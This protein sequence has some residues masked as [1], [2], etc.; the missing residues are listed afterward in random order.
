MDILKKDGCSF[1]DEQRQ[2][3]LWGKGAAELVAGPGSGKTFVITN[4]IKTLIEKYGVNPDSIIVIT[5]TRAA[6][7]EMRDRFYRLM[8]NEQPSVTF[9]TFH[10]LF[11]QMLKTCPDMK[12][13]T[14][15]SESGKIRILTEMLKQNG[16]YRILD[17]MDQIIGISEMFGRIKNEGNDDD[18]AIFAS[19]VSDAGIMT[20]AEK[21]RKV[22]GSYNAYM[23][24][25]NRLDFDDMI[26]RC[27]NR[28]MTDSSFCKRWQERFKYILIDEFQDIC[29]L[30][31]QVIKIIASPQ[32]NVFVVGDDDQ[33]IYG[34]RGSKPGIMREFT[35]DYPEASRMSLSTNYR[36]SETIVDIADRIISSNE[37]RI[38]KSITAY[39]KGGAQVMFICVRNRDEEQKRLTELIGKYE[40]DRSAILCRK[41]RECR[42]IAKTLLNAHVSFRIKE[43][44]KDPMKEEAIRD[45][46]GYMSFI[47]GKRDRKTFLMIMNRPVRYIR[48]EAVRTDIVDSKDIA[49]YYADNQEMK[50]RIRHLFADIDRMSE[51]RPFLAVNFIRKVEGYD[52][53]F[54]GS[55]TSEQNTDY[56]SKA[57]EFQKAAKEAGS[58]E[59]LR[60]HYK[61]IKEDFETK[62]RENTESESHGVNI[63]TY[64]GSKGLEFDTVFL[65]FANEGEVPPKQC[66]TTE[67]IEEERRMFYVAVTRAKK[68]LVIM[69][70]RNA[71]DAPSRFITKLLK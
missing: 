43:K 17:D 7:I 19:Y 2:A 14:L 39:N 5:F 30:Q 34:F 45:L 12:N 16:E 38:Q 59:S 52:K 71:Q 20:K 26:L 68:Q 22:Y 42:E 27:R 40:P 50:E 65:P 60:D 49:D 4:R 69:Y 28:L 48:R 57:D 36:S 41:N 66:S 25:N 6:A 53:W 24:E 58:L 33:S 15:I 21:L 3:I 64:H 70:V 62:S 11:F 13:C 31:Y 67:A 23:L 55:H 54:L 46:M 8:D 61:K 63:M 18:P 44:L 47:Y 35:I 51:M 9:G 56:L 10:S 29:S 1:S 37:D 32:N